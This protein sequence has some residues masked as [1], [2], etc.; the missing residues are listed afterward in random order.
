MKQQRDDMRW[1]RGITYH[2]M[3]VAGV[4]GLLL[5]IAISLIFVARVP[6]AKW[7]LI[8]SVMAGVV[9]FAIIRLIH[10]LRPETEEEEVQLNLGRQKRQP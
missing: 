5:T 10:R 9:A 2:A 7:F 4:G 6:I 8:G 1:H 3:P